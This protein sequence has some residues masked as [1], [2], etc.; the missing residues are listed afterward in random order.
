[1]YQ[2]I[3]EKQKEWK[4]EE[5]VREKEKG[6]GVGKSKNRLGKRIRRKIRKKGIRERERTK[7]EQKKKGRKIKKRE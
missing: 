4:K 7:T 6:D 1:M 3:R 5:G 2:G